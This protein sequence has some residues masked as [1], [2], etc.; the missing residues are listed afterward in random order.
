VQIFAP[1]TKPTD[2]NTTAVMPMT[3]PPPFTGLPIIDDATNRV[4][5]GP[6][7]SLPPLDRVESV[8]LSKRGLYLVICGFLFHFQE[9]MYGYVKVV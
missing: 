1:G 3:G 9:N 5:R 8:Q 7:P 6:D 4:Y 2:I